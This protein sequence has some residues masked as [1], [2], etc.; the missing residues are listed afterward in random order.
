MRGRKKLIDA[1]IENLTSLW[2]VVSAPFD[3]YVQTSNFE[4]CEIKNSDWPNKLWFNQDIDQD[5]ITSAKE[6]LQSKPTNFTIPYWNIYKHNS[7]DLLEK[8][9]FK[10]QF[11]QRGMFLKLK[12]PF[13]IKC[14]LNI[15]LVSNDSE[16]KQWSE[17]FT[18]SF[19]YKISSE[20]IIKTYRKIN[21]YIAYSQ[22]QAVG[23]AISHKTNNIIGVH[24]VGILPTMRRKGLAE[25][26]MIL[27][28]NLAIKDN[29]DYMT[30]QASN[31]GEKMYL[32]LGFEL[33]FVIKNYALQQNA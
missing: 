16:A 23:T 29:I 8:N 5:I 24:S 6:I 33:L 28:I 13:R 31:M 14:D 30:I 19:E 3:S 27:L 10:I 20:T 18:Q 22:N 9:G 32:K 15:K 17:L 1:N 2:K 26:I 12:T 4:Y 21:Y 25:Q 7:S 11:E